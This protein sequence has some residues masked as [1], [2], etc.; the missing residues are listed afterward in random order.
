MA[1]TLPGPCTR[2]PPAVPAAAAQRSPATGRPRL[3]LSAQ[4]RAVGQGKPKPASGEPTLH[5][6]PCAKCVMGISSS[7]Y[8]PARDV[9]LPQSAVEVRRGK[10]TCLKLLSQ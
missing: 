8:G 3:H 5:A 6:R 1:S 10:G 2:R 9:S 4:G 7:H